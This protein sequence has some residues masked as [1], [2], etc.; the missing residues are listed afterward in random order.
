MTAPFW[1]GN[2][3]ARVPGKTWRETGRDSKYA[4]FV[5]VTWRYVGCRKIAT[6]TSDTPPTACSCTER[7]A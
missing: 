1:F 7:T 2:V 6:T 3:S 5:F 4:G